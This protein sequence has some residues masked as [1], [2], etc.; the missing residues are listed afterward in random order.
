MLSA[1]TKSHCMLY[2]LWPAEYARMRACVCLLAASCAAACGNF[3]SLPFA[4]FIAHAHCHRRNTARTR[5]RART[6]KAPPTTTT[7]TQGQ[8]KHV[9]RNEME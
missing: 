9:E 4:A 3:Q 7:T 5:T 2:L 8:Q 6:T 1:Q